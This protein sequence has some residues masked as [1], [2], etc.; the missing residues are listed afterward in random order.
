MVRFASAGYAFLFVDTRGNGGETAGIPFS[1]QL[2]QQ[3]YAQFEK[4]EMPQYYLSICD[5]VSAQKM[6][7]TRYTC[8]GLCDG[9]KQWWPVCCSRCRY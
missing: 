3:D 7:S 1:Q 6:L 9:I 2:I 4:G 8:A 5:L